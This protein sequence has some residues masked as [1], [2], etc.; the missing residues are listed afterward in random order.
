MAESTNNQKPTP[1]EEIESDDSE[2][3]ETE[4]RKENLSTKISNIPVVN[5]SLQTVSKTCYSIKESNSYVGYGMTVAETSLDKAFK[6]VLDSRTLA[7]IT[8]TAIENSKLSWLKPPAKFK[9]ILN[10]ISTLA[11]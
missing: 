11:C 4:N 1:S 7:P 9:P 10:V 8:N 6:A 5:S 2:Q 3:V